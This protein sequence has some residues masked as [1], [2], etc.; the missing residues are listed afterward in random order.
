MPAPSYVIEGVN[1]AHDKATLKPAA[2]ARLDGVAAALNEQS[3]V[4]YEIRGYTDSTGSENYN[5]GLSE[6]RA[7]SVQDY[8]VNKGVSASQVRSTNGFGE[9]DPVASNAN[10]EGRAKNRRV[11]IKPIL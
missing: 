4:R 6:R 9:A 8:L 1:F 10:K 2:M 5:Q 11:E 7:K 3:D